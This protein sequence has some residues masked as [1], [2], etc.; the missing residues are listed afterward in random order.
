M[1]IS[2]FLVHSIFL[3]KRILFNLSLSVVAAYVSNEY[4][5]SNLHCFIHRGMVDRTSL[6]WIDRILC[7]FFVC[8]MVDHTT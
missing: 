5:V 1:Y 6:I 2:T 3:A 8:G 7:H 4:S